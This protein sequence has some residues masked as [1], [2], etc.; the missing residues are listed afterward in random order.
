VS[1]ARDFEEEVLLRRLKDGWTDGCIYLPFWTAV[2]AAAFKQPNNW[3]PIRPP[4]KFGAELLNGI[5][6][7]LQK[8]LNGMPQVFVED[9]VDNLGLYSAL[10]TS[11]DC[12][13]GTDAF[14]LC[15]MGNGW[16][17]IVTIDLAVDDNGEKIPQDDH[18]IITREHFYGKK[19]RRKNKPIHYVSLAIAEEIARQLMVRKS[20]QKTQIA[21]A[22]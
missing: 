15:D 3:N 10:G 18:Y 16:G 11:L 9:L 2:M 8:E 22:S 7:A 4:T 6:S 12:Y 19:D 1:W 21:L 5:R 13:H 14:I 17:P 20:V